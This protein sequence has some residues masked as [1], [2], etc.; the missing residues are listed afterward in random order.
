MDNQPNVKKMTFMARYGDTPIALYGYDKW[1][2]YFK[3]V[4]AN[5]SKV[6]ALRYEAVNES[7]FEPDSCK[8]VNDV[9][10]D[11]GCVY[12]VEGNIMCVLC[13]GD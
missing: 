6:W 4:T 9:E 12:D 3:G 5:G 7:D 1:C 8:T 10:P 2:V 13:Y 11:S